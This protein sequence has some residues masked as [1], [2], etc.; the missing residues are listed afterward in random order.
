M[1]S[2][3]RKNV[4]QAVIPAIYGSSVFEQYLYWHSL[5]ITG[6]GNIVFLKYPV[7][8][9]TNNRA[10]QGIRNAVLFRKFTF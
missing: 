5:L 8:E 1:D 2:E 9:P 3:R 6:Q 7:I 10:E 4:F